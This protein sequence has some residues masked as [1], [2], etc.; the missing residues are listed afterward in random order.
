V[1]G[2]PQGVEIDVGLVY[3]DYYFVEALLRHRGIYRE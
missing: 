1:G 3:A 2:R